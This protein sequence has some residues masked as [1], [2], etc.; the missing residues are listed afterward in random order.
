MKIIPQNKYKRYGNFLMWSGF[1]A[2][3]LTFNYIK[4]ECTGFFENHRTCS[5]DTLIESMNYVSYY[6][7]FNSLMLI[8]LA[9]L[10][11]SRAFKSYSILAII[12][13][14]SVTMSLVIFPLGSSYPLFV[15]I[16]ISGLLGLV[17]GGP[18]FVLMFLFSVYMSARRG[19][20]YLADAIDYENPLT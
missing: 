4:M 8:C 20:Q 3:W 13:C 10:L 14:V 18:I 16:T 9:L 12:L 2:L 17:V 1:G 7:I 15:N 11:K 6:L 19:I 5:Y